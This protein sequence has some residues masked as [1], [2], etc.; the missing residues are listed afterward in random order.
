MLL[1]AVDLLFKVGPTFTTHYCLELVVES[2][3]LLTWLFWLLEAA[4]S[5]RELS[6]RAI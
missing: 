5:S 3:T 2:A 4:Y 1:L 6:D